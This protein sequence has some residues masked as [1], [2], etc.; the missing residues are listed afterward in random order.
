MTPIVA[1]LTAIIIVVYPLD[2][3]RNRLGADVRNAQGQQLYSGLIDVY[4]KIIK[5]DGLRGLYRGFSLGVIGIFIY[6]AI[7]F[8]FYDTL[9]PMW[10]EQMGISVGFFQRYALSRLQ[11]SKYMF[12]VRQVRVW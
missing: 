10:E 5:T 9:K 2:F 11:E 1:L 6:R 12:F 8:G 3:A 7:Y 4:R